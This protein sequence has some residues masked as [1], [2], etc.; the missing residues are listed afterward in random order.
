MALRLSGLQ[1]GSLVKHRVT[2][3]MAN[4]SKMVYYPVINS[5]V[6]LINARFEIFIRLMRLID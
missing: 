4:A 6:G 2:G 5:R 3:N 1:D